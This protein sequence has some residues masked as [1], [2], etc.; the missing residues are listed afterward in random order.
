[1]LRGIVCFAESRR[2]VEPSA[3]VIFD[4]DRTLEASGRFGELAIVIKLIPFFEELFRFGIGDHE[5]RPKIIV[6]EPELML[7]ASEPDL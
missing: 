3:D 6:F 5:P 7:F 4:P 2:Q 1:M